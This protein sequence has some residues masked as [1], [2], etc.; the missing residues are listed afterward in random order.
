MF[1]HLLPYLCVLQGRRKRLVRY[2]R[3]TV[4]TFALRIGAQ[5]AADTHAVVLTN[6]RAQQLTCDSCVGHV[7]VHAA[8]S[9]PAGASTSTPRDRLIIAHARVTKCEVVHTAL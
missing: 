9:M 4:H 1:I 6:S 2:A 5:A 7:G 3:N 8:A